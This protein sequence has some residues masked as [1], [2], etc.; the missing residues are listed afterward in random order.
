M[1]K[2]IQN[3]ENKN[4]IQ[5]IDRRQFVKITGIAAL[6]VSSMGVSSMG[7]SE[8]KANGVSIIIDPA[9]LIASAPPSKWAVKELEKSLTLKGI[10]VH[11][12]EQLN[13]SEAND[14]CIVVAGLNSSVAQG[15][16]K[17]EK[18]TIPAV[19]EALGLVPIN[20][21]GK[22]ILLACGY[23]ERGVIYSLLELADR[24]HFSTQPLDSLNIQKA[25]IE[26]P[27][28]AIRS[29]N[30]LFVSDIED[31]PWYNDKEMWPQYLTMLTTQRFN[32]FN[33]SFGIGYDWLQNVTD[34]YFLFA[35]PFLLSVP[36][37]NVRVPQLPDAER[38][39]NLEMLKF[40]SDQ[41]AARGI[42]FQLGIWMHGYEWLR[43]PNPNYTIEGLTPETQAPYCRDAVRE[44][45]KA[46]PSI[47]GITFRIHAEAGVSEGS[48]DFWRT[49][50][51]GVATCGRKVNIDMHAKGIDQTMIDKA[52]ETGLTV[53]ASPKYWAEH[54]GMPYQQADIRPQEIPPKQDKVITDMV[55]NNVST[56]LSSGS[57]K[58]MR[59]GYGDLL[60]K[61][62]RYGVLY[63]IWPGTQRLLLWGDPVTA[64]AHA[65]AFSF[66]GSDG[67]E[68]MEPLSFK[69]RR[70]SGIA[71]DRCGYVDASLKP[72]WDWEK[73]LYTLRVFGR[74]MYN[75]DAT[76]DIWQRYLK[77]QF[78][79]GAE[80]T[81]LALG[82]ATRILPIVL[83]AHGTSAGNNTYWPEMY[84]NQ[85][86][87]V[88]DDDDY[89]FLYDTPDP[90]IFGNV[91][92][93]DPQLFIGINDFV[94]E[95]LKGQCNG[96]YT[97]IEYAQWIEDYANEAG[98][99]LIQAEAQAKEKNG[100]EF[101]RMAIDVSIQIGLGRFFGAKFRAG[102]LYA[103]Y[104]QSN[105]R[106][107]LE[108]ALKAYRRAI[109]Y[110]S[111]L[112]HTAKSVYMPDITIGREVWLRGHWLDRL[113]A[114]AEDLS[115]MNK[116]LDVYSGNSTLSENITK[117][118]IK[119][120]MGKPVRNIVSCKHTPP[121]TFVAGQQLDVEFIFDKTP[122]SAVLYYR[123]VNQ[124]ER[125]QKMDLNWK[126]K[127]AKASIPGDYTD[128]P[129]SI[130]YYLE[131]R[132]SL[133]SAT[134]YPGFNSNQAN[135]PYF[136]VHNN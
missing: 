135:Q 20:S 63:R 76:S 69:G 60:K 92:P 105:D 39:N 33:L 29:L 74:K 25:I 77:N 87:V 49:V 123:H 34:G 121:N 124:A 130:G 133:D 98:K 119:K 64:A 129:Y 73:Y 13:Q 18:T 58:F 5:G 15:L 79:A 122:L 101:R 4:S 8:I 89:S 10:D 24:V 131:V 112:A 66:C 70:G 113:P 107:A 55:S 43:S 51:K 102:V 78:G 21:E 37:Y 100:P 118:A 45:L 6:G 96:K 1:H 32:R 84:T 125:Y 48:Y 104:E 117:E 35:Y 52:L 109:K 97:P 88:S 127:N 23:D 54:M 120:A 17:T 44:L 90:K 71:G 56:T 68:L 31:K 41:T 81:E 116:K 80:A 46:C 28:N 53:T 7:F 36:G 11:K 115:N 50:F 61:D 106:E 82:N 14:I 19:S 3:T 2:I 136:I 114:M 47:S 9:D 30:R 94:K 62:R 65:K 85:P 91:T 27:A 108:E 110:W 93:M 16:L 86:I 75:P 132:N 59:Y 22:Q 40:I 38:D 67:V 134:I 83:T 95:L 26:R 42:E 111:E 12:Y 128:S 57:R 72:R 103:I 99:N 126:G